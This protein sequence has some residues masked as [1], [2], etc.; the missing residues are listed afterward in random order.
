[1]TQMLLSI[2]IIS[3]WLQIFKMASISYPQII[4]FALQM[5]TD[6]QK[7]W[8][9]VFLYLECKMFGCFKDSRHFPIWPLWAKVGSTQA[10]KV[11]DIHCIA[12]KTY[13]AYLTKWNGRDGFEAIF[14]Y[15]RHGLPWNRFCLKMAILDQEGIAGNKCIYIHRYQKV[16]RKRNLFFHMW[17]GDLQ[18]CLFSFCFVMFVFCVIMM[19]RTHNYPT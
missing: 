14:Q 6:S 3:I 17:V 4:S 19:M 18:D 15:G 5:T 12:Y 7:R 2:Q 9:K 8:K 1:M 13:G 11:L 10:K 16:N